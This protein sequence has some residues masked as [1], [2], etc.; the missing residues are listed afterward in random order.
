MKILLVTKD[1]KPFLEGGQRREIA[2]RILANS[3][4]VSGHEVALVGEYPDLN[5]KRSAA[6]KV[7][8]VGAKVKIEM[9]GE[10]AVA[11]ILEAQTTEGL[12]LFLIRET[13]GVGSPQQLRCD[14]CE[15]RDLGQAGRF[16]RFVA[17][18]VDRMNPR[19]DVV[20]AS[21]WT[22]AL[23]LVY[24]RANDSSVSAVLSSMD[25]SRDDLDASFPIEQF[26]QLDLGSEWFTPATLE[27]Y[28]RVHCLKGGMMLADHVV[29]TNS[30]VR[31]LLNDAGGD[32]PLGGVVNAIEERLSVV[33]APMDLQMWDPSRDDAIARPFDVDSIA[34]KVACGNAVLKA[35]AMEKRSAR[36]TSIYLLSVPAGEESR[37][38]E[39]LGEGLHEVLLQLLSDD[40]RLL[41]DGPR[42]T[43]DSPQDF[44]LSW[45]E[46]MYPHKIGYLSDLE[47]TG[48][49]KKA[50]TS[51]HESQLAWRQAIA[52]ADFLLPLPLNL[53]TDQRLRQAMRYGCIPIL[54][55]KSG[56]EKEITDYTDRGPKVDPVGE[57]F[58]YYESSKEAVLDVIFGRIL[59]LLRNENLGI[60][61]EISGIRRRAMQLAG[62]Y[63]AEDVASEFAAVYGQM[64]SRQEVALR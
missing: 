59:P 42:P 15:G 61:G 64:G 5:S 60:D 29:L 56:F 4:V 34:N 36:G 13:G 39:P 52:A 21:D 37:L 53:R 50:K 47:R 26:E 38:P 62:S 20:Q 24:L 25:W 30:T 16:A 27:F 3:L 9:G 55:A 54:P 46:T 48:A 6:A 57:G 1:V 45:A 19:P 17:K 11:E 35:L 10:V 63:S 23:A 43:S 22:S 12:Q 51:I 8:P 31:A 2:L 49:R 32:R 18:L 28:G 14:V 33:R 7:R 44:A 41:I 40:V 58:Y